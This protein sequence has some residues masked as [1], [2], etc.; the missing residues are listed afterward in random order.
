[1][2]DDPERTLQLRK[3]FSEEVQEWSNGREWCAI[4]ALLACVQHCTGSMPRVESDKDLEALLQEWKRYIVFS[5]KKL[6]I[7]PGI[8]SRT[9]VSVLDKVYGLKCTVFCE[10]F[11][12]TSTSGF[13]QLASFPEFYQSTEVGFVVCGKEGPN[14]AVAFR[15]GKDERKVVFHDTHGNSIFKKNWFDA[16]DHYIVYNVVMVTCK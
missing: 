10:T 3:T 11:C 2:T 6:K 7:W 16:H 8:S 5:D 12:Q 14:H 13:R 1:M 9:M 4:F 15:T